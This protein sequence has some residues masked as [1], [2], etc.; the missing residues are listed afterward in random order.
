MVRVAH[1]GALLRRAGAHRATA[2][3]AALA[4]VAAGLGLA[5]PRAVAAGGDVRVPLPDTYSWPRVVAASGSAVVLD[6]ATT[7]TPDLRLTVDE[8]RSFAPLANPAAADG[9]V[10]DSRDGKLVAY[11]GFFDDADGSYAKVFVTDLAQ[12]TTAAPVVVA[13]GFLDATDPRTAVYADSAGAWQAHDLATSAVHELAYT[14]PRKRDPQVSVHLA[15]GT[16]VLFAATTVDSRDRPATGHLDVVPLNGA[17]PLVARASVPGLAAATL[18]GDQAVYVR[19]SRTAVKLCFRSVSDWSRPQ[20]R[21]TRLKGLSDQRKASFALHS[22]PGWVLWSLSSGS[23]SANYLVAGSTAPGRLTRVPAAATPALAGDPVRPLATR[24]TGAAGRVVGLEPDGTARPRFGFPLVTARASVLEV[25]PDRVVG[26]DNRP[27]VAGADQRT[28]QRTL[29]AAG[30]GAES[31]PFPRA[32][33]VGTSGARTLLDDGDALRLYDRGTF[34]RTLPR[35]RYGSLPGLVSGPYYPAYTLSYIQALRVDGVALKKASIRGMFGSLVLVRTNAALGRHDVVDL[36]TGASV[37]VD[38]PAE[39]RQQGFSLA[40]LWGDWAFGYTVDAD[41]VPYALAVN[42]RTGTTY[43]RYGLPVDYGNGF[44]VLQ[45]YPDGSDTVALGVW[46]PLTDAVEQLPDADWEVVGTDG[47]RRL[48]YTTG[49]ELVVRTLDVVPVTAPRLLGTLAPDTLNLITASRAW[50]PEFD[51]TGPLAAGTLTVRDADGLAVRTLPVPASADGS[52][53]GIAWD[54]RDAAG[55]DVPT[56]DYTWHLAAPAADGSGAVV[57]VDGTP[58]IAGTI[59]VVRAWLG[60]VTGT[61]PKVSGTAKVGRTLTVKSGTWKPKRVAL[62]YQWFRTA[63]GTTTAIE[64]ATAAAYTVVAADA[65]ARLTVRVRGSLDGYRSR[66]R[67]SEPT[68]RIPPA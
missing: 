58:G 33:D 31:T 12:N 3:L 68:K 26:L 34:V 4:L 19:A 46:N 49:S 47:S 53:R 5:A 45:Y 35:S 1:P 37:R 54:G 20:C 30:I 9:Q 6:V 15:G 50:R 14:A 51:T 18:R 67:T 10:A 44:V 23:R 25:T 27:D 7:G 36:V 8:G 63:S 38:V 48:A 40:G 39:Y 24:G 16:A 66:S 61:R 17:A 21:S 28:W 59:H 41:Y 55:A 22:G 57:R 11:Q 13:S 29:S 42:Y 62:A 60:A 43:R 64:G 65:G 52:L 56:G 2:A 32:L